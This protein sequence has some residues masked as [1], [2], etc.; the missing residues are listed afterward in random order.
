MTSL[1]NKAIY[2]WDWYLLHGE[3]DNL[4]AAHNFM[5]D[6]KDA[7]GEDYENT[8]DAMKAHVK[9]KVGKLPIAGKSP[10]IIKEEAKEPTIFGYTYEEIA[11]KQGGKNL[12]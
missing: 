7:G 1:L 2:Y 9:S 6:Y 5:R 3:L 4:V 10:K 11:V 8:F 12:R